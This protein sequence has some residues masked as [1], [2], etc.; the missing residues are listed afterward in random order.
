MYQIISDLLWKLI[1]PIA[2]NV[3]RKNGYPEDAISRKCGNIPELG[4]NKDEQVIM[5]HGVSVGEAIALENF[6]AFNNLFLS[7]ML[8]F[9]F[10]SNN[11]SK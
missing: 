1:K 5:F 11:S 8:S 3:V 9:L 10:L 4:F 2:S 7:P 6:S